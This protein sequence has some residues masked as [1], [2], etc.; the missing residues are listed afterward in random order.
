MKTIMTDREGST[1]VNKQGCKCTIIHYIN[2][3]EVYVRFEDTDTLI[4]TR[5]EYCKDGSQLENPFLPTVCGIGYR[6]YGK[7]KSTHRSY[8]TW[9][10]ILSRCYMSERQDNQQS[11]KECSV[12]EE[13]HN[14]QN[15]AQWY[16]DNYYEVEGD[17]TQIDKDIL[18]K[19][20][21][22][23]SPETCLLVPQKVN[24]LFV[25]GDK[26]GDL[27]IG[28]GRCETTGKYLARFKR[29][30]VLVNVGRYDTILEAFS[31]YKSEKEKHVKEV[32]LA[33][34]H[35]VPKAVYEAMVNYEIEINDK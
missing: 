31:A 28:V 29:Y 15:F 33:Y 25:K 24:L 18:V 2:A 19:G 22:V 26:V 27:P 10:G 17:K 7:Y 4:K 5:Y 8:K 34:K 16:D 9:N 13:W 1:F 20:N 12:C 3:K 35:L 6:G 14:F 11:Y 21:K 32:A 23:Y 30:G